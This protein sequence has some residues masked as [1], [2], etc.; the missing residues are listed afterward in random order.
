MYSLSNLFDKY[1]A[2]FPDAID[3]EKSDDSDMKDSPK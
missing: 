2:E 1:N 3:P